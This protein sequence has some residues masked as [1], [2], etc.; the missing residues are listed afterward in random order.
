[1]SIPVG[2]WVE[3]FQT[4]NL[5][6]QREMDPV[7]RWLLAVRPCTFSMTILAALLGGMLAVRDG[8]FATGPFLLVLFGLTLA[9]ATNNM[10]NDYVDTIEGVDTGNYP[11]ANYAPHP[12]LSGLIP[13]RSLVAAIVLTNVVGLGI[14]LLLTAR[15][16]GE[17]LGLAV[18]G[19]ALS[20]AYVAWPLKLKHRGLGEVAIFVI[21]GPLMIGGTYVALAGSAPLGVWAASVPYGLAVMAVIFGKHLD[22]LEADRAK[23]VRSLPVVLGHEGGRRW[24]RRLIIAF[25]ATTVALAFV[26]VLPFY[27]WLVVVTL[28][29]ARRVF[30]TLARPAPRTPDEAFEQARDIIPP[31]LAA[32][33]EKMKA[34]GEFPL[35]PLWYVAWGIWWVRL[36][37]GVLV[38]GMIFSFLLPSPLAFL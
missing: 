25:Y 35:W 15:S 17:V 14:A 3:I 5:S 2:N 19:V 11:R 10:V 26:G 4:C 33:F 23:G 34:R 37:G 28:P 29:R 21:W 22:K 1:M 8:V 38:L 13:K 31:E 16:G 30:R 27:S 18:A 12:I 6:K 36:A 20:V 9:H 32:R 24:M 7:S